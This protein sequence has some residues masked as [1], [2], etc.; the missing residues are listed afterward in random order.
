MGGSRGLLATTTRAILSE[1]TL[2]GLGI[3]LH[4]CYWG[5]LIAESSL[6]S[7]L[8]IVL[9]DYILDGHC[10][11][12]FQLEYFLTQALVVT[13]IYKPEGREVLFGHGFEIGHVP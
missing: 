5:S 4:C 12:A 6:C 10:I 9:R 11:L 8:P 2:C 7:L 1:F 3:C 13:G